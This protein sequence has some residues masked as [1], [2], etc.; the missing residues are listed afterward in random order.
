[1]RFAGSYRRKKGG[2]EMCEDFEHAVVPTDAGTES[3]DDTARTRGTAAVVTKPGTRLHAVFIAQEIKAATFCGSL[4]ARRRFLRR[5]MLSQ[6]GIGR[7]RCSRRTA[8]ASDPSPRAPL[9]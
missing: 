9:P 5:R 4:C 3:D 6:V 8:G 7:A 2:A 1:M